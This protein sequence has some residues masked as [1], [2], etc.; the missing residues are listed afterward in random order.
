MLAQHYFFFLTF[1]FGLWID[2][3]LLTAA[4]FNVIIPLTIIKKG[5]SV[6][7]IKTRIEVEALK[8]EWLLDQTWDLYMEEGFE[9]YAEELYIFQATEEIFAY[10]PSDAFIIEAADLAISMA[11][12]KSAQES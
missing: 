12:N 8:R 5:N 3:S 9:E 6:M 7:T 1:T 11:K 2:T 10:A 4:I